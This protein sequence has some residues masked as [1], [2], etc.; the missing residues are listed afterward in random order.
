M[1][2]RPGTLVSYRQRDWVVL[3]SE[4]PDITLL[5]PIGGGMREICGVL[6]PL[7]D[8][9]AA[10]L[11]YERIK[12]TTFPLP[13]TTHIQD[14]AAVRLLLDAA[15]LLLRD[16]ATADRRRCRCGQDDRGRFDRPRVA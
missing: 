9:A 10:S 14:Q 6:Q 3:P 1:S 11:P 5:R 4:N 16:G 7:A 15:R 2:F 12:A 8:L 13:D